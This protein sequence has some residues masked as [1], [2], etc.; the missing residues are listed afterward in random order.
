MFPWLQDF[1][2]RFGSENKNPR[3]RQGLEGSRLRANQHNS[4]Y[5]S[6]ISG[7]EAQGVSYVCRC[8]NCFH[9]DGGYCTK[10]WN[11]MDDDYMIPERDEKD[12]D[13]YC[14]DY[15]AWEEEGE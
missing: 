13:D 7:N 6:S 1:S 11:N 2:R 4:R 10:D 5:D 14:D 15:V 12:P 3:Q 8:E 9:Y